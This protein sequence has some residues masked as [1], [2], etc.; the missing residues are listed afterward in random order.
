MVCAKVKVM[1]SQT[2]QKNRPGFTQGFTDQSKKVTRAKMFG[3][4]VADKGID[5]D[6]VELCFILL[7]EGSSIGD[8]AC[9]FKGQRKVAFCDHDG[10]R[11]IVDND[12]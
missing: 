5:D 2:I 8:M 6:G 12:H 1:R 3:Y 7:Q 10:V 4:S 11:V 9:N